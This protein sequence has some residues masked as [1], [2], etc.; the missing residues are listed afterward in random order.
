MHPASPGE[1]EG[2]SFKDPGVQSG[3][4]LPFQPLTLTFNDVHYFVNCP[5]VRD[6]SCLCQLA[7]AAARHE[8]VCPFLSAELRLQDS[9]LVP[10]FGVRA[11][12]FTL[13]KRL[14]AA[15]QQTWSCAMASAPAAQ[16]DDGWVTRCCRRW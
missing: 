13:H 5:A 2:S 15:G 16:G 3:M 8:G 12:G 1:G 14:W 7:Q 4:V 9:Q 10:G 11:A 6:P